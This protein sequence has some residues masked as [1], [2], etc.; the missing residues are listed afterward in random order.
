MNN[1]PFLI[2]LLLIPLAGS[3][4]VGYLGRDRSNETLAKQTALATAVL[5]FVVAIIMLIAYKPD[6]PRLQFT[7]SFG[8]IDSLGVKFSVGVDGIAIVM[9]GLVGLLVPIVMIASWH[10]DSLGD[11]TNEP[12][13]ED[14][15]AP[16]KG[17]VSRMF[18][19]ILL[20]EVFMVGVFAATD[21][22]LFYVLFEVMLV[23]MYFI[24]GAYG[25]AKRR[26]AAMKF[27]IYSLVGGLVMLA[28]VIGL[29]VIS[30]QQLG[31][32]TF[33]WDALR[34]LDLSHTQQMWLFLGFF[35]AF[36]IKA[37]LVPF[38]TWLPKAGAEAPIAGGLLL[39][40]ILD[41]VGTFGFLRYCLPL[42]PWASQ[43]I[44]PLVLVLAVIGIFYASFQA[45]GEKDIKRFVTYTSIAHFGFIA[46]GIFA[47]T[48]TAGVGA[49]LYMVNHGIATGLL[50][51]IVGMV[52]RRGGS[53]NIADYGGLFRVAPILSGLF[54][55]ASLA[56]LALP[57]TNSF[58]SEFLVLIGA[59]AT[60]PVFTIIASVGIVFSAIY[61]LWIFQRAATGPESALV[62][63][64]KKV[65]GDLNKRE[66]GVL[67]PLVILIF[68]IGIYPKPVLDIITPSVEATLQ[69]D[70]GVH[71]PAPT[72]AKPAALSI[73][74]GAK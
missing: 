12:G 48:T 8:W 57:G 54:L 14:E 38:H 9:I 28:S 61:A 15:I 6:G 44:A 39:I 40:G 33:S 72:I 11:D 59:Y 50:F 69:I 13:S 18:A 51:L 5:E 53:R 2:L 17:S 32:A 66:I 52:I 35:V 73:N 65:F 31:N 46:L 63:A 4:L 71:D 62:V 42:F 64:R 16:P 56:A 68:A 47:F 26:A 20:L 36:A 41:K 70:V 60:V 25:S 1:F 67:T 29:Y 49:V 27:F 21:V 30:R 34:Q 23:P 22:F 19:W 58:V 43:K 45:I 3:I 55:L 7:T 37:P 24:I 74:G 10:R